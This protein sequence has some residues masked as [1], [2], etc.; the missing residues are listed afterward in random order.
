MDKKFVMFDFGGVL[1]RIDYL[2]FM[3]SMSENSCL[4]AEMIWK[5][6]TKK[7]VVANGLIKAY[8]QGVIEFGKFF[9]E[10]SFAFGATGMVE[11]TFAECW[12]EIIGEENSEIGELLTKIKPQIQKILISNT[13]QLHWEKISQMSLVRE[14]FSDEKQQVLSFRVGARKPDPEIFFEAASRFDFQVPEGIL[15][16]DEERNLKVFEKLGGVG[17]CYDLNIHPISK[18]HDE[19]DGLGILHARKI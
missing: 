14:F 6:L 19:L 11:Q 8:S 4:S 5:L 9:A 13:N 17:I 3:N 18:L 1:G 15:V 10:I 12:R 16:D 7:G 2:A